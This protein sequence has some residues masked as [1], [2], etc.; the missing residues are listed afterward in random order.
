[1][2]LGSPMFT[3]A[4]VT[5]GNGST[6][7]INGDGASGSAPYVQSM[8][9][10]GSPWDNA[11]LP[12]SVVTGGGTVTFS[13]GT[14]ANTSWAS[15]AAS[16]PPSFNGDLTVPAPRPY[17]PATSNGLCLDNSGGGEANGNVVQIYT[18]NQT[19]SQAVTLTSGDSLQVDGK[20]VDDPD[21][22]T[23][24]GTALQLYDCNS[25]NPQI[26]SPQ[27]DGELTAGVG[28]NLCLTGGASSGTRL[29]AST[30]T[31]A[32]DQ[33]WSLPP[34]PG[35][36]TTTTTTTTTT[37]PPAAYDNVG[38]SA[39]GSGSAANFDG[40][41]Y[42]YSATALSDA[43][44]TP[45]ST[46]TSDGFSF[47]WP[48]VAAGTADNY[49]AS[50]QTVPVSAPAGSSSLG[51]LGSAANAGTTGSSGTVT[52]TYSD[53][54]TSTATLSFPD[55]CLGGGGGTVP[56]GTTEAVTT[57]YRNSPSAAQTINTYVF[58]T[59]VPVTSSKTVVSVTLPSSSSNGELHVFAI[60]G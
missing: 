39:D 2:A 18:C 22:N 47:T 13:L 21:G 53:G 10:N 35:G 37:A 54:S 52:I 55:W 17:G 36:G 43:G 48:D 46:V 3:Q 28:N 33:Q 59:S 40:N 8:T 38:V 45:G 56:A 42:S 7:T 31:D 16:A 57:T 34:A 24:S 41:G 12:A 14:T 50:G 1:M 60:G 49:E 32:T 19:L 58:A 25:S 44:V 23:T 51:F 15:A 6:L 29:T 5:L 20:C 27:A 9:L 11:Y 30:C 4:V 26:W